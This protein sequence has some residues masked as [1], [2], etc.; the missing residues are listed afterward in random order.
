MKCCHKKVVNFF[1]NDVPKFSIISIKCS[2]AAAAGAASP[3]LLPV[4]GS[5]RSRNKDNNFS[6]T[7]TLDV[8]MVGWLVSCR[9]HRFVVTPLNL[10]FCFVCFHLALCLLLLLQCPLWW[11][12]FCGESVCVCERVFV[13]IKVLRL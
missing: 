2:T 10:P 12:L 7:D 5:S 1:V 13:I 4:A 6:N 3:Q 8:W 9:H 11:Y